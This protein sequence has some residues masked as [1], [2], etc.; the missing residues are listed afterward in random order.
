V[1]TAAEVPHLAVLATPAEHTF[2]LCVCCLTFAEC[3]SH[4]RT[5]LAK[6][7]A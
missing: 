2:L 1:A 6:L 7:A 4:I 3:N 5:D